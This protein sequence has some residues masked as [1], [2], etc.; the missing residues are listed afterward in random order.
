M[1]DTS[2]QEFN[3]DQLINKLQNIIQKERLIK[4]LIIF[5]GGEP[6]L[7]KES[8]FEFIQ[9]FKKIRTDLIFGLET[10]GTIECDF[11]SIFDS[12]SLSPKVPLKD[13]KLNW[14]HSLKILYPYL[15]NNITADNF[16]YFPC[17][18][19]TLQPIWSSNTRNT[20][21]IINCTINELHYLS[22]DWKLGIQLHKF[23]NLR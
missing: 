5:T 21:E 12:V 19:K 18:N 1:V 7:Q 4:P 15:A 10:N 16:D 2:F 13:I 3:T 8:L 20:K 17:V 9:E 11:L 23:L 22:S 6:L 14:C